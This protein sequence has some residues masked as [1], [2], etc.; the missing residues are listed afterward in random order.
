MLLLS[1]S[2]RIL[3]V[4]KC[5][6]LFD[7]NAYFVFIDW[8]TYN[9]TDP[10]LVLVNLYYQGQR[11]MKKFIVFLSS[12]ALVGSVS[13]AMDE[14]AMDG[15][16]MM[17]EAPSVAVMLGGSAK[18]GIK[19]VD[20]DASPD[21]DG[22]SLI[23]EYEVTFDS[24]GTTD[25]GLVFGASIS[26]DEG[27][28]GTSSVKNYTM[29][30]TDESTPISATATTTYQTMVTINMETNAIVADA[31]NI[32]NDG[33][34]NATGGADGIP[35][36]NQQDSDPSNDIEK[37]ERV[38][39]VYDPSGAR[40]AVTGTITG[41]ANAAATD[42]AITTVDGKEI[43]GEIEATVEPNLVTTVDTEST[44]TDTDNDTDTDTVRNGI[45]SAS[46]YIGSADGS[47]KLKFGTGLDAG[48]YKIGDIGIAGEGDSFYATNGHTVELSGSFG[49]ADFAITSNVGADGDPSDEWSAGVKYNAG[50]FNIG[51]G[52]DSEKGMGLSA[53][54]DVSGVSIG[55]IYTKA[56]M[57]EG[58]M[59]KEKSGLGVSAGIPAGEGASLT[60]KYSTNE[61]KGHDFM[62][63]KLVEADFNYDL[64]GGATLN[65]GVEQLDTDGSKKTTLEASISMSF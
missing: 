16:M 62:E 55:M 53:G 61:A 4:D 46:V 25:G 30:P 39:V 33:T 2:Y 40:E 29:D 7:V 10:G 5:K 24:S 13:Y 50:Q 18:M 65:A 20:D 6:D 14:E 48:I 19:N 41:D 37:F 64:G 54:T 22:L 58:D 17:E 23:R 59:K 51:V 8:L 3:S 32:G 11:E 38:T 52:M 45:G 43:S 21:S 31:G 63:K 27:A 9:S 36:V 57:G 49:G 15:E 60:V 12:V 42:G 28:S 35:D 34:F 44:D 56:E 47:W 26:F 1:I